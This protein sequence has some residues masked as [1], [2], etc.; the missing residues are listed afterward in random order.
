MKKMLLVIILLS[1][2]TSSAAQSV[3]YKPG[4][5]ES[6]VELFFRYYNLLD[7]SAET[8]DKFASL[9][10]PDAMHQTGPSPRQ[11]GPVFYEGLDA[12]RKMAADVGT[13]YAE[14]AYRVEYTSA[15]EKSVQMHF[16]AEGPWGGTGV[17]VEYVGAYTVKETG[18]RFYVP[19]VAVFHIDGGK[20]TK[21]RFYEAT[22]E[23]AEVTR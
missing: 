4:S 5:V 12:I 23:L 11:I 2:T 14:L 16:T 7:G 9:Y 17:A 3:Q 18:K 15:K 13:K 21:V 1:G 8:T 22:S 20:I 19:G 10:A 6:I